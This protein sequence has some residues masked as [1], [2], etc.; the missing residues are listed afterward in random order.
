MNLNFPP[1]TA[2][3]GHGP[4]GHPPAALVNSEANGL[5]PGANPGVVVRQDNNTPPG[6]NLLPGNNLP[7]G[8]NHPPGS[9]AGNSIA[10]QGHNGGTPLL[11]QAAPWAADLQVV[12]AGVQSVVDDGMRALRDEMKAQMNDMATTFSL[13]MANFM[14]AGPTANPRDQVQ[15]A[16]VHGAPSAGAGAT[17][18]QAASSG[19]GTVGLP[20]AGLPQNGLPVGRPASVPTAAVAAPNGQTGTSGAQVH[21]AWAQHSTPISAQATAGH[22]IAPNPPLLSGDATPRAAPH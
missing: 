12:S 9:G 22:L 6:N 17:I 16:H 8:G 7:P 21:M 10:G 13:M 18:G 19:V 14:T 3:S 11:G 1:R 20:T 15:G 5:L 2:T 4:L